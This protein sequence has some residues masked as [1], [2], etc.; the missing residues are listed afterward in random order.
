ME[1]VEEP[2]A[3]PY[4]GVMISPR[5]DGEVG[6]LVLAGSSGRIDVERARLLARHGAVALSIRWF[7]GPGQPPGICEVS[8]ETF[9]TAV[10]LLVD[11]GVRRVGVVGLSKG[12]EA[13]LL[14]AGVDPRVDAVVALSPTSMV[15]ANVGPGLDGR[16]HPYRSSWTW[17][18]EP[19]PFVPY[20]DTWSPAEPEGPPTACRAL[21]ESSRARFPRAAEAA[22]IPIERADC[23][24]LLVAGADDQMWPSLP[25]AEEL[26]ARRLAVGRP[27][28]IVSSRDAGHRPRLPGESPSPESAKYLYGGSANADA[29]LGTVA[30]PHILQ[31][32][33]LT[34]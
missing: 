20:D 17:R 25:Y 5:G 29:A 13:A 30:W 9:V 33:Q 23:E 16:T 14:T 11:A 2:F 26:A 12:A 28:R 7:G 34:P 3:G 4:E 1:I 10:D 8:L 18:G 21:Y 24:L 6:V 19:V 32:L 31:T 27:A 15:W 22:A